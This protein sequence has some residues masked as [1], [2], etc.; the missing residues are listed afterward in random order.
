[1]TLVQHGAVSIIGYVG[2]RSLKLVGMSRASSGSF[3][4]LG[5]C[6]LGGV[7]GRDDVAVA[8][9]VDAMIFGHDREE[10]LGVAGVTLVGSHDH[11]RVRPL[12]RVADQLMHNLE[13][14]EPVRRARSRPV[15]GVISRSWRQ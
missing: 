4:D 11:R 6:G 1:M 9:V 12:G 14:C 8:G 7:S 5:F 13:G 10:T 15:R 3:R 2:V